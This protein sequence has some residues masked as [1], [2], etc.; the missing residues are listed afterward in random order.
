MLGPDHPDIAVSLNSLADFYREQGRYDKAEPLYI[1]A[2]ATGEQALGPDHAGVA[3]VLDHY[4]TLLWQT[5]RESEARIMQTR[6][7]AI[8]VRYVSQSSTR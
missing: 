7:E 6:A 1:R 4:A 2:M 8:R 3:A 5:K